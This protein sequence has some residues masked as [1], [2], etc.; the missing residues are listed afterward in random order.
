MCQYKITTL[1]LCNLF[2]NA[3]DIVILQTTWTS[4]WLLLIFCLWWLFSFSFR[5]FFFD[6]DIDHNKMTIFIQKCPIN[7]STLEKENNT[8]TTYNSHKEIQQGYTDKM[9]RRGRS[10]SFTLTLMPKTAQVPSWC[11]IPYSILSIYWREGRTRFNNDGVGDKV[12]QQFCLIFSLFSM[13]FSLSPLKWLN[14]SPRPNRTDD[15]EED[16][17]LHPSTEGFRRN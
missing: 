13:S 14:S 4:S 5:S 11:S 6:S 16:L 12:F 2:L 9:D 7:N 17:K 8:M 1:L 15:F 3:I 10:W